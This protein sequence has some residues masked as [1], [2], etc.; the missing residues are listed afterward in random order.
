MLL[1]VLLCAHA[2]LWLFEPSW[3][4]RGSAL[5]AT[6]AVWPLLTVLLFDRRSSA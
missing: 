1:A 5:V 6:A 4:W 3:W 2:L